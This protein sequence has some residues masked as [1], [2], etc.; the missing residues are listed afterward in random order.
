MKRNAVTNQKYATGAEDR[1]KTMKSH[2]HTSE[3]KCNSDHV[4]QLNQH[5]KREKEI[6]GSNKSAPLGLKIVML[7][8][9]CYYR[10]R[11]S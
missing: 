1:K 2:V 11:C 5:R 8:T 9:C 3:Q 7:F 6:R 10:Q 4:Y